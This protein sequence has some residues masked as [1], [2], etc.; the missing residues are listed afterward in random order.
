MPTC[1]NCLALTERIRRLEADEDAD[2]DRIDSLERMLAHAEA[3]LAR[4]ESK[5]A[6]SQALCRR[7]ASGVW[8][9]GELL[10][11]RLSVADVLGA[12]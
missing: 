1:P 4:T 6:R 9:L 3:Q 10:S 11:G 7:L 2:N 5:L 8:L 12:A